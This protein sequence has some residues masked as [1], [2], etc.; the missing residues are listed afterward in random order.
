MMQADASNGQPGLLQYHGIGLR[1]S[2]FLPYDTAAGIHISVCRPSGNRPHLRIPGVLIA[3]FRIR[4][5]PCAQYQPLCFQ[6]HVQYT[7]CIRHFR[8]KDFRLLAMSWL[9]I[10]VSESIHITSTG[11]IPSFSRELQRTA[12][13]VWS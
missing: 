11:I 9:R 3:D 2:Q 4:F 1:H 12:Y 13:A 5:L 7:S 10:P 6:N 8:T